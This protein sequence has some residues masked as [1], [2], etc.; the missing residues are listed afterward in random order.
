[1]GLTGCRCLASLWPLEGERWC[2]AARSLDLLKLP[3]SCSSDS[4]QAGKDCVWLLQCQGLHKGHCSGAWQFRDLWP[5][6]SSLGSAAHLDGLLELSCGHKSNA[7]LSWCEIFKLQHSV[8]KPPCFPPSQLPFLSFH[9]NTHRRG[10]S[11]G[12]LLTRN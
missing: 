7:V 12:F 5:P 2:W 4:R 9:T 11:N 3:I 10:T 1:M 8:L 6:R